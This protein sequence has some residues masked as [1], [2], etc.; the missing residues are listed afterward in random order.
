M[1][2][3]DIIHQ[4]PEL[5]SEV[6]DDVIFLD[7]GYSHDSPFDRCER[8]AAEKRPFFV[9]PGTSG[10]NQ[11]FNDIWNATANI[12]RFV[13]AGKRYGAVGVLNTDWGDGGHF[14]MIGCSLHGAVLGAVLSWNEGRPEDDETF[15]LAFSLQAF[16][17][18]KGVMGRVMRRAGSLIRQKT[19]RDLKTW[20]LWASPL[21]E[22]R[23]GQEI[24]PTAVKSMSETLY[25]I[26][27]ML[28]PGPREA[29]RRDALS[30]IE[31]ALGVTML[32]SLVMRAEADH[33][34]L[35]LAGARKKDRADYR[36][37][38]ET[39]SLL[40]R[41]VESH[42]KARSKPSGAEDILRVIKKQIR[43]A[44]AMSGQRRRN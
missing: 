17:D 34:R 24:P 32:D 26:H 42:W 2:W 28:A 23:P 10:C 5:I 36:L 44:R 15:D 12:R 22:C 16:D 4:H 31:I 11:V 1:I 9:C 29:H 14:N 37:W 21:K 8:L 27:E 18:P 3:A 20:E 39:A 33:E 13:A 25:E 41:W 7:W 38:L 30:F 19:G 40:P 6:P 35:G 43:D